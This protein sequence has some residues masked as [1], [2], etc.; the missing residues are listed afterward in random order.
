MVLGTR[1]HRDTHGMPQLEHG[2]L[3][4]RRERASLMLLALHTY[5]QRVWI[6]QVRVKLGTQQYSRNSSLM[7]CLS[8]PF[9]STKGSLTAAGRN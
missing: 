3:W 7:P 5:E 1:P 4:V 2:W 9:Q 8:P 6:T